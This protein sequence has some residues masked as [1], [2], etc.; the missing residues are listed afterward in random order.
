[1][2][3]ILFSEVS[4]LSS[5][6][7][8]WKKVR[9]NGRK[10]PNAQMRRAVEEFEHESDAKL[11]KIQRALN[12]GSF[13]FSPQR[14]VPIRKKK[15][16]NSFRG[17]V[18]SPISNR[19]VER[20]I[21]NCLQ[22]DVPFIRKVIE[23]P[24]SV[25]GVPNR[26][27]GHGISLVVKALNQPDVSFIRS[28]IS[29][30]FDSIP[31]ASVIE[32]LGQHIND[33]RLLALTEQA[34]KVTLFNEE[35]LG[36]KR[37]I[38]PS[39][40]QGVA[41]GSPL[42]PLFGN[43]LLHEFDQIFNGRGIT[44]VRFID[45][46]IFIGEYQKI[47]KAFR[48]ASTYLGNIGLHCHDPFSKKTSPDK[49]AIGTNEDTFEFLGYKITKNRIEPSDKARSNIITSVKKALFDG[50]VS[51]KR[52][53]ENQSSFYRRQRYAQ[54][55][56]L[57]DRI[58]KGW[59]DAYAYSTVDL[60]KLDTRINKELFEFSSWFQSYTQSLDGLSKRRAMG[61]ALI[62]DSPKKSLNDLPFKI[63]KPETLRQRK[64]LTVV[65]TDGS[66]IP[67]IHHYES[68]LC[69]GWAAIFHEGEV[70][71]CGREPN[72]T[73]NRM[74][75]LA[76]VEALRH[77]PKSAATIIRTDSE[78]VSETVNKERVVHSN[79]SLWKELSELLGNRKI[80]IEW[81][82]AHNNDKYNEMADSL[83]NSC[84]KSLLNDRNK[85]IEQA[86]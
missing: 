75:L 70:A 36:E 33:S 79:I 2:S 44:C 35:E 68:K 69:G 81:V 61:V 45:D 65:S 3:R 9:S 1:M 66:S 58:I 83:A 39:D 12:D 24:T 23:T 30:F 72:A 49:A 48:N 67:T 22:K 86:D 59:S 28:D 43:I 73:N 76:V 21:L 38:F 71:F 55:L 56:D 37:L 63:K 80:K 18:V 17:I 16:S 29:S 46:F 11:R 10:S 85:P 27:V 78:Y 31:A 34:S 15:G 77:T 41:Q 19:I 8:A 53:V 4:K 40:E 7:K 74:E 20:S 54:T 84:A 51:I 26:G 52:C 47:K 60:S 32:T 50:K 64:N 25:G 14:G 62:Q 42:S 6:R 5:L 13:E 57:S 82:K